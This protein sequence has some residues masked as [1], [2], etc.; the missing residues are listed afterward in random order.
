MTVPTLSAYR[1]LSSVFACR[2]RVTQLHEDGTLDPGTTNQY[3]TD[4]LISIGVTPVVREGEE[5][6]V[7]NG[8]GDICVEAVGDDEVT[9]FD[10]TT[11]LCV[12]DAELL[13]LMA[14]G[15]LLTKGGITVGYAER[16]VGDNVPPV[17]VEAWS[18]ARTRSQQAT[19]SSGSGLLYWRHVW[20]FV[21]WVPAP[22][23]LENGPLIVQLNGKAQEN[24]AMGTGPA[25]DWPAVITSAQAKFLDDAIPDAVCGRQSFAVAGSAS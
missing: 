22:H 21:E 13:Y 20:P 15:Y 4:A 12:L 24:A 8:C 6:T 23:T 7:R 1:C 11:N 17:C 16:K 3:V 9:R 14:G 25:G 5:I 18:H 19:H 10:L 2:L